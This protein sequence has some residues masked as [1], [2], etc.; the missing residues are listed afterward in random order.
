[1]DLSNLL[2]GVSVLLVIFS[3]FMILV[4]YFVNKKR[5]INEY[6][7]FD[8]AKEVTS[9]YDEIN[10][11]NSNDVIFSEYDIKR[12]VIRLNNKN[13]DSN[14]YFD[15][16]ISSILAG[17]SLVNMENKSYFKFKSVIKKISY[18][19]FVSLIGVILSYFINN[20]FDAKIGIIVLALLL[21][22]QYMRYL[23]NIEANVKISEVLD[24][25]F[26]E[27]IGKVISGIINFNKLSFIVL[28]ILIIRL[29][30]IILG[31]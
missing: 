26:Y 30:V 23:I 14:S 17:Y 18:M 24:S 5:T 28:L 6:S 15:I 7:G 22:Y 1:M 13:Y 9:N 29:V 19:G 21:F 31:I 25:S 2:L 20:T 11:V 16:A 3:Y 27:K 4:I 12:N 10:I 8:A